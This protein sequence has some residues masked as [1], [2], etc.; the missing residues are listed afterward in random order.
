[1]PTA[2]ATRRATDPQRGLIQTLL[3]ERDLA[4]ADVAG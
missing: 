1:M 3:K 4:A 2:T